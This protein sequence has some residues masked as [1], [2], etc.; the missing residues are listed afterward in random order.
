MA[1]KRTA[2]EERFGRELTET[3]RAASMIGVETAGETAVAEP[4]P[5]ALSPAPCR[6]VYWVRIAPYAR[7]RI[8]TQMQ[9]S[10]DARAVA[11]RTYRN[12]MQIRRIDLVPTVELIEG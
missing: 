3:E 5:V 10:E 12:C 7:M 11:Q 1:R 8:D 9:D 4:V 2:E 6:G